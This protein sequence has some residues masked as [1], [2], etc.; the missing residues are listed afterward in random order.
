[1]GVPITFFDRY[2]PEQFEIV[3]YTAKDMGVE[4]LKFYQDL[5]QSI[6]GGP[7]VRNMK[8]ARFSPMIEVKERPAKTCY[9]AS[10]AANYLLKTYGRVIIRNKRP[11]TPKEEK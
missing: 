5:E 3:G 2:N 8:S 6:N 4:C 7:F 11:E 9:R 10:N 1:M